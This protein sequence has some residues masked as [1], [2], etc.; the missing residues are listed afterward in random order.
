MAHGLAGSAALLLVV[1]SSAGSV[2][3]G[4]IY[5]AVF[6]FGSIVGMMLVAIVVSLPVLWSLSFGRPIF[7]A[8]QGVA[9]LGSVAVGLTM[10]FHIAFGSQHF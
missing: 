6:G 2:S 10:M 5:I 3:E 8:V 9:S 7:L 4:L 1:L